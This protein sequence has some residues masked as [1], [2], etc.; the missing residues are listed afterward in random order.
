MGA[1]NSQNRA[2]DIDNNGGGDMEF[3]AN[4]NNN[5]GGD[6]YDDDDDF[7]PTIRKRPRKSLQNGGQ[8]GGQSCFGCLSG[9]PVALAQENSHIENRRDI[10][11]LNRSNMNN[12]SMMNATNAYVD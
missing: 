5:Y 2:D 4:A 12:R 7:K 9:G 8:M 6:E 3:H 11:D 1:H 10:R